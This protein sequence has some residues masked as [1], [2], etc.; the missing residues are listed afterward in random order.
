LFFV[1]LF[2]YFFV[3]CFFIFVF[4]KK[5][6]FYQKQ[7]KTK[8]KMDAKILEIVATFKT[9]I[10]EQAKNLGLFDEEDGF[11]EKMTLLLT[12]IE[13]YNPLH[14]KHKRRKRSASTIDP[15]IQCMAILENNQ[16]CPRKK[17]TNKDFCTTH[18]RGAPFG[19][20]QGNNGHQNRV[21]VLENLEGIEYYIDENN[22][23]YSMEAILNHKPDPPVI[24]T[25][26]FDDVK[27]EFVCQLV[28]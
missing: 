2:Y 27:K 4:K 17:A 13:E 18:K 12:Y 23:I 15:N 24:G 1:F 3:F 28:L 9:N 10:R 21:L 26:V 5:H 8:K 19:I 16:Q 14:E 6:F 7:N 22:R 25:K 11:N 20:V